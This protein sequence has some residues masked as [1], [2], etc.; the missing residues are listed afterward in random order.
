MV[1]SLTGSLFDL[2]KTSIKNL[3][4]QTHLNQTI[5]ALN[6]TSM[7]RQ[8]TNTVCNVKFDDTGWQQST[9]PVA[10]GGLGLS[11]AVNV[12]LPAYASSLSATRQL[13]GQILQ[14]VFE[15]CPTSEV[16]SVAERWTELGH[17]LTTTDK[18][19]FQQYWSSAVH[20]ALFHSLKAGAPP[21]R[22]ARILT[23]AQGHSGDWITAYPIAQ[24]GTRLDDKT[25]RISVALRVGLNVCLAYQ[26]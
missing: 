20:K 22:L 3:L 14:D 12:S 18:K 4:L 2:T 8:A 10:Q 5:I 6:P 1:T 15:S 25:L 24:V 7:L 9:L 23:A 26:C 16:D 13:V 21:S 19:P 11:S 17:E